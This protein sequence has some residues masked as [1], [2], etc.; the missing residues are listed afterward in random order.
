MPS[1][2]SKLLPKSWK[3]T[4]FLPRTSFP[5]R[6]DRSD[7]QKHLG[8]CTR[9]LYRWQ[10]ETRTAGLDQ[11]FV[12]H[13]G[14]PFANGPLHIGHALNKI[15]KDITCRFQLS[16]G[17]RVDFVPGWDCHGLPIEIKALERQ[18]DLE[19]QPARDPVGGG[20]LKEPS[21]IRSIA[22]RLA[23]DAFTK[24]RDDFQQWGIMADWDNSWKTMDQD[25]ELRQLEVFRGMVEKG[26][27]SR[28]RKPVYWSPS[29]QSALAE[30]ELEYRDDHISTAAYVKYP[31]DLDIHHCGGSQLRSHHQS[32]PGCVR[33][34]ALIWTTTPW[35]LPANGA[36]AVRSD[37]LYYIVNNATHGHLLIASTAVAEVYKI[38]PDGFQIIDNIMGEHLVG[39][40]YWDPNYGAETGE[41]PILSG[42][43]V[44]PNIGTGLVHLA[45]GHGMDDYETC[46]EHNIEAYAPVDDAGCFVANTLPPWAKN[47]GGRP[48]LF[49]GN[50]WVVKALDLSGS[51]V[52]SYDYRHKYPYDWRTKQPVIIRATEQWFADI[53][54]IQEAAL[55][56]L[57]AVRFL[58]ES[59]KERLRS[60]VSSRAEW[61]ISR[62]RAW[63]VPIPALYHKDTGEAVMTSESVEHIIKVIAKRGTNAWF[64]DL[65]GDPGWIAPS[66]LDQ[67]G[68][69]KL[70]RGKDTMDVWFDSGTSWTTMLKDGKMQVCAPADVYL[71]G[72]DQHRGWFQSSLL[73]FIARQSMAAT[74][75]ADSGAAVAPFRTLIT[76]GFVLDGE[77][78]KMSKSIGNVISPE[79]IIEGTLL[80]QKS[81]ERHD[82]LGPDA[83][84]L[85]VASTDYTSDVK[86]NSH[87][88]QSIHT[89]LSKYRITFRFML[90]ALQDFRGPLDFVPRKLALQH[91]MAILKLR[92][93]H[94]SVRRHYSNGEYSRAIADINRY[95]FQDVSAF[96]MEAVKDA[97][98]TDQGD[99]RWQAQLTLLMIHQCL[100]TMLAPVTPLLI[101][102]TWEHTSDYIKATFPHPL[103]TPWAV[104]MAVL[105]RFEVPQLAK[106]L[107][108]LDE[109]REAVKAAQ[110]RARMAKNMG[111]SLD[112]YVMLQFEEGVPGMRH[113]SE[114]FRQY[115]S[116]LAT[117]FV[118]SRV[119]VYVGSVPSHVWTAEWMYSEEFMVDGT[120]AIAHVSKP[121]QAKC[122]RCWRFLA[123]VGARREEAVCERCEGVLERL[124]QSEPGL[125]ESADERKSEKMPLPGLE[126]SRR[127]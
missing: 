19:Q 39:Q 124:R 83:L 94:D 105:D 79:Q 59:G 121:S 64:T 110:E 63:G 113:A 14:P 98:Y 27:I 119:D 16:L 122:G 31:M 80:Q 6:N 5:I 38:F 115:H 90:G 116:D 11:N 84:R 118:V 28:R 77:G 4:I 50:A 127:Y 42:R 112:C 123:P 53:G 81:S 107:A 86:L 89:I 85:W 111:S 74:S 37:L 82:A 20:R 95:I 92:Q 3:S 8:R 36:I 24:Q 76:H 60:L 104:Q 48:V 1:P 9:D 13:D 51:L 25:F 22:R 70:R 96:Y 97:L 75:Q 109:A 120:T 78:R 102:E 43:F 93:V 61:C 66:L 49:E 44:S 45:P 100:Q 55:E 30:A 87:F 65:E 52:K 15:L 47:L 33:V 101:E 68:L 18:R 54:Q 126:V 10:R 56:S 99:A 2:A 12:L 117:V 35:T 71:E 88:L 103:Q 40:K 67:H 34:D 32:R 21:E 73:T 41:R 26:L 29:S 125:F 23:H 91:Q 69:Y 46:Q 17:K 62:Q 72:T 57:A 58:P 108:L 106:D 7:R 114:C